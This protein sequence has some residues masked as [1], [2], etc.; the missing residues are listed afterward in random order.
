MRCSEERAVS[1]ACMSYFPKAT[2]E[3]PWF[4]SADGDSGGDSLFMREGPTAKEEMIR[5]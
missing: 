2:N 4:L 1:Y 3:G 5:R